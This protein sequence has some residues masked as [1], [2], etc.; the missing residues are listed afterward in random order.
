VLTQKKKVA[1]DD[2]DKLEQLEALVGGRIIYFLSMNLIQSI[3]FNERR[4][5]NDDQTPPPPS[6]FCSLP[7]IF[8]LSNVEAC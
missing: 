7:C 4:N 1:L 8:G 5:R 6:F 3:I 2:V